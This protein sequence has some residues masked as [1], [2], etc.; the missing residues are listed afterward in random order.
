MEEG[1]VAPEKLTLRDFKKQISKALKISKRYSI[2]LTNNRD[3]IK[4]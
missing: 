1:Q 4:I 3:K 2:I